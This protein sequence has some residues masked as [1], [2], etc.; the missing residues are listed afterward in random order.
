MLSVSLCLIKE[1]TVRV[2]IV[3]NTYI[4]YTFFKRTISLKR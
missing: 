3:Y 1:V 4:V 2:H